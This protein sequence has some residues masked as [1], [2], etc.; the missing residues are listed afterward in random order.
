M[1]KISLTNEQLNEKVKVTCYNRTK[2][3]T[4]KDAIKF[5]RDGIIACDPESS[6]CDRYQNIYV[7]LLAGK[8]EVSDLN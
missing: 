4:R 6:E 3:Y 5:F 1:A 2:V 7:G 8:M